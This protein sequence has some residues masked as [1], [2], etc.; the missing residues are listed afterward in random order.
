VPLATYTGW[1][2]RQPAIGASDELVSLLGSTI[3]FPATRAARAAAHDP[4][5][6]VEERYASRDAYLEKVEQAADALVRD[7]YLLID[8]VPRLVQR[9]SD[10]WDIATARSPESKR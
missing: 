9:A 3:L 4:R 7:G 10:Q 5:R 8:D 6:S 1:N 2:F